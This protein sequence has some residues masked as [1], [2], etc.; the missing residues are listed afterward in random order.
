MTD[1]PSPQTTAKRIERLPNGEFLVFYPLDDSTEQK[2]ETESLGYAPMTPIVKWSLIALRSYLIIMCSIAAF[3]SHILSI[4]R[5][6]IR[7]YHR[8]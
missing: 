5:V 7:G 8:R 4:E 2:C 1:E 6:G 3:N